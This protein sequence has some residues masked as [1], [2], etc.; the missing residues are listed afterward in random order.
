MSAFPRQ[1]ANTILCCLCG[2]SMKFNSA[3]MCN[4]CIASEVDITEGIPKHASLSWCK[5]CLRINRPPWVFADLE[6]KELLAICL[7]T[8][9]GLNKVKLLDANF[10]WTEPHSKRIKV[11]LDIQKEAL[12]V[13]LQK[14]FV[15]E[16]KLENLFCPDCH[17]ENADMNALCT[18]QV[19]QHVEHKRTF[20]LLEQLI[21][22]RNAQVG[23]GGMEPKKDGIDFKFFSKS[24]ATKFVEFLKS[25]VPAQ[26][27]KTK[28]LVNQ[29]R[30]EFTW[31]ITLVPI[32]VDDLLL[33]SKKQM[34]QQCGNIGQFLLC[35]RIAGTVHLLNPFTL[36]ESVM[37][38]KS[39]FR[40]PFEPAM[41]SRRL[42]EYIV[43]DCQILKPQPDLSL[44]YNNN[45]RKKKKSNKKRGGKTKNNI[46]TE[47]GSSTASSQN[48]EA[49]PVVKKS[50]YLLAEVQVARAC[51]L[52]ANDDQYSVLTHLGKVL[53]PGDSVMGY[54]VVHFNAGDIDEYKEKNPNIPDVVLVKKVKEKKQRKKKQKKKDKK[55]KVVA[56]IAEMVDDEDDDN[57]A[58]NAKET[59]GN[60]GNRL[61]T[62]AE[63][64]PA[65]GLIVTDLDQ[66]EYNQFVEE[67]EDSEEDLL[68]DAMEDVMLDAKHD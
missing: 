60:N 12:G 10:I 1:T 49:A 29:N 17:Q 42:I 28:S 20:F 15:V 11:K 21:I 66:M 36:Q 46:G 31:S 16:Y 62:L 68:A 24:K 13:L 33:L 23:I 22:K 40:L 51:D 47:G 30:L 45:K 55:T 41:N 5:Q 2:K 27:K 3:A 56:N 39:Y 4:A 44:L 65:A 25:V 54:D 58:N 9:P 50:R 19:R 61:K 26:V 43:L 37:N 6:S 59:E 18:V 7:R 48:I 64:R 14:T 57:I 63:N 52:G 8:L 32:C 67:M 34:Q 53:F 35:N 38:E